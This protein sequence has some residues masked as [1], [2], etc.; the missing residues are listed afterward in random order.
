MEAAVQLQS[1]V[2]INLHTFRHVLLHLQ[3][4]SLILSKDKFVCV[5]PV[6][7]EA[8]YYRNPNS[9][10]LS[11]SLSPTLCILPFTLHLAVACC[12]CWRGKEQDRPGKKSLSDK[13]PFQNSQERCS[14][15]ASAEAFSLCREPV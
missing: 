14:G 8:F 3:S 4:A 7:H 5:E 13:I 6:S 10:S 9:P 12:F 2:S 1:K 15:V 11:P